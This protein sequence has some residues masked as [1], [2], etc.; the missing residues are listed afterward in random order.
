MTPAIQLAKKSRIFYSVYEYQHD[1]G[2]ASYGLEAAQKMN[3]DEKRVFKTLIVALDNG[4]LATAVIPVC[5]RLSMKL[6][7]RAMGAKK[8]DMAESD[9]VQRSTGYVLGGVSPLGQKKALKTV[10]DSSAKSFPS[11]FVSAGRRG[12]EIELK[13]LDLQSLTKATFEN[14]CQ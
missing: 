10:I 12:L 1:P 2:H 4:K 3:V 6:V 5:A 13:A 11:V 8:A 9:E 14:I 7:A